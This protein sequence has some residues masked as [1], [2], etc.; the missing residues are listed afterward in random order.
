M[1]LLVE[2]TLSPLLLLIF[3]FVFPCLSFCLSFSSFLCLSLFLCNV[4]LSLSVFI[5]SFFIFS[6]SVSW[7]L[8]CA[9]SS[10]SLCLCFSSFLCLSLFLYNVCLSL[11]VFVLRVFVLGLLCFFFFVFRLCFYCD[12]LLECSVYGAVA[13]ED[14]ALELLLKTKS[15]ACCRNTTVSPF[16][17]LCCLFTPPVLVAFLW[18]L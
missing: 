14:G 5:L 17:S 10:L 13:A 6:F 1:R 11:S 4:C 16:V 2:R 3:L 15:R 18:L 12:L 9:S 7:V 8:S